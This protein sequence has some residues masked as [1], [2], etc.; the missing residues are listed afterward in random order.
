MNFKNILTTV[1][2][3]ASLLTMVGTASAA[4]TTD[5]NIYGA[6]A[7]FNFWKGQ[8]ATFLTGQGCTGLQSS[9]TTDG[10]NAI[11]KATCGGSTIYFRSSAKASYDGPL[12]IQRNTTNPNR[13]TDCSDPGQ[14][15]MMNEAAVTSW[16]TP[17]SP[18]TMPNT[19]VACKTVTGGASDVQVTSFQ[20]ESHGLLKGPAGGV[21]TDR[22]FKGTG[23]ITADGLSANCRTLIVPFGFFVNKGVTNGGVTVTNLTT[24]QARLIFSGQAYDWSE[25]GFDAKPIRTCWRHAGSGTAAALDFDVM[26]PA[27]LSI[28]EDTGSG[29]YFNDGSSDLMACVNGNTGG[30]G[31]A[32]AD[33]SLSSYAN[34]AA[35]DY[36]GVA[37]TKANI[38]AGKYD[39]YTTQNL[40]MATPTPAD[41][42]T[43]CSFMK[44]PANNTN[45]WYANV[46]EMNYIRSDDASYNTYNPDLGICN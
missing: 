38:T 15:K 10:K 45:A 34:V 14:R 44:N 6:S 37:P 35:V 28:M 41:M 11:T 36:N 17:A 12:A 23:S 30:V 25:L 2:A 27:S 26:R 42:T 1:V 8:A 31:Y 24:A 16:G 46:C 39:F 22:N 5:I 33:Q 7:Q 18:T 20:Q 4:I 3:G 13:T 40:Y 9:V 19:A 29:F 21:W 43:L 32:D